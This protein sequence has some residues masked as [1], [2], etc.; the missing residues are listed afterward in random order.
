MGFTAG[1]NVATGDVW[2][3]SLFNSQLG[4][5]GSIMETGVA[6]ITT[7]GDLI[8]SDAASSVVRKGVGSARQVLAMNSAANSIE[9]QN[10]PN[11]VT[12]TI[13]PNSISY[14]G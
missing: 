9:Y 5:S 7:A 10:S 3:S 1:V 11:G 12:E 8:V 4:S 2:S 6:K 14:N 13:I